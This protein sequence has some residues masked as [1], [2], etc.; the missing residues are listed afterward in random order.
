MANKRQ[1]SNNDLYAPLCTT[2]PPPDLFPGKCMKT[3]INRVLAKKRD[4][5]YGST[6]MEVGGW[7]LAI[8]F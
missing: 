2:V 4:L 8:G 3:Q 1:K 6:L 5:S 7:Q